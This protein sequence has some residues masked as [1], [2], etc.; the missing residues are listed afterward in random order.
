MAR[1]A[2]VVGRWEITAICLATEH[3]TACS[4][5]G[6][7]YTYVLL[8]LGKLGYICFNTPSTPVAVEAV[9]R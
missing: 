6:D 4:E 7:R 5:S 1:T 2:A 9:K 3:N 8:Y